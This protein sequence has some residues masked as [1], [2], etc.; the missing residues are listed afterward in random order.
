MDRMRSRVRGTI[1]G[2]AIGDALG[3]PVEGW[4]AN[5]IR[6]QVGMVKSFLPAFPHGMLPV[7]GRG[8]WTDDT[9]LMFTVG[10]SFI[11]RKCFDFADIAKR[12]I[13]AMK[14]PRRWEI[15]RASCRERV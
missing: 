1:V 5:R 3:M 12:H 11:D 6:E 9:Q 7:L 10:E 4:S 2:T 14:E 8:Q 15:G 13:L